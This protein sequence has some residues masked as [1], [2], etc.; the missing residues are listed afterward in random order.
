[1]G[2]SWGDVGTIPDP[3]MHALFT[4]EEVGSLRRLQAAKRSEKLEHRSEE[5]C[6]Y[7]RR[8]AH[9]LPPSEE[10]RQVHHSEDVEMAGKKWRGIQMLFKYRQRR[11]EPSGGRRW[12]G[13]C[14]GRGRD[15]HLGHL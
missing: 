13:S 5:K 11:R 14:G 7:F 2:R 8:G 9:K 6:R 3:G 4:R 1:M 15:S 12:R 10:K